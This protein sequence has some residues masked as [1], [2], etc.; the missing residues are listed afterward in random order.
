MRVSSSAVLGCALLFIAPTL[1]YLPTNVR[2]SKGRIYMKEKTQRVVVTGLGPIS[3]VGIGKDD[4][5]KA[6]LEGK[7]GIDKI[8]GFDPSGLTC[9]IGAEVKGFDAKPYFKD[10]K[11]AVRNDRVTLM[12]VAAS[13]IAVD[14]ARLDLATVEGERFGVVVGSAFGG[15]QTLETQIQS[16][17][18]KGPGAVSPFAVPMLLSNLISGVI[19]L[20]NGAKGPN[21]VVNSACAASTHALGLAYAHIAHGE[22]DVCLAGG[23]EAAVTPFGYAGFCSMKAMATKYNDNPSQGSRP[24]DKDRCGFVM[25]EG[26]GMLVLE[27]LEH[28]QKRGAHIYA[29]VAGFGQACDAHHITTPHPEGAGLAKAITLALD[30]AGLD[31]GDLTYI[32]AHGT[33]TAYNDK[34]ETLAVKKALGEENAKRMYLS[35]TKGSTGHTLGAAGGLEAIA[36]VL[37]I[38]TLTL[39]P[40]INYETPDPDCDLNVVPNK[41]IKVAEIKAAASQSAGFGGHD[42]VVIFK[43]FK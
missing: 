20:E 40:T 30:D 41:P 16:M 27:S 32:N 5:W 24:F 3:A 9:Q 28:A 34:F 18:E 42:S 35:S 17:N 43:P 7:C 6:L 31:K 33:S 21:Y 39:P 13:R 8:S 14:D 15:L 22:A 1:A 25:G 29:E 38:E 10:K 12:G 37:A 11:S 19:A 2:A 4:F 23:A 36:T 26:A